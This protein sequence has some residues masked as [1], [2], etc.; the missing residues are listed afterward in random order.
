MIKATFGFL[1]LLSFVGLL[2]FGFWSLLLSLSI[3]K[4]I[5]NKPQLF[6]QDSVN[7]ERIISASWTE[8]WKIVR[9]DKNSVVN[10]EKTRG[11]LLKLNRLRKV[12]ILFFIS[13]VI[14]WIVGAIFL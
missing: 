8:F 7:Q 11:Q 4:K 2:I 9:A 5:K 3:F 1:L 6:F 10:D 14:I 12:S 13:T